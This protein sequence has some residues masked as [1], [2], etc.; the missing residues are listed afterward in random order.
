MQ[1]CL[2]LVEENMNFESKRNCNRN[3]IA[4]NNVY[5]FILVQLFLYVINLYLL[6]VI[7]FIHHNTSF[8]SIT[9]IYAEKVK[10]YSNFF[11]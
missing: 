7:Y 8:I 4:F 2:V 11:L 3:K 9:L 5:F 10:C 6:L 1:L